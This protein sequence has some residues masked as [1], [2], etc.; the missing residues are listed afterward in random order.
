M[1][2]ASDGLSLA[3]SFI[4]TEWDPEYY[5][6]AR[7][8]LEEQPA[9]LPRS[10]P[11]LT[12]R[13]KDVMSLPWSQSYAAAAMTG[14]LPESLR[15]PSL[16]P[17]PPPTKPLA[18][19]SVSITALAPPA[20]D[21]ASAPVPDVAA[22][23][24]KRADEQEIAAILAKRADEHD[25]L[26]HWADT[27]ALKEEADGEL[28][29]P[30][31]EEEEEEEAP[32]RPVLPSAHEVERSM[33]SELGTRFT[34]YSSALLENRI[35][36]ER[37]RRATGGNLTGHLLDANVTDYGDLRSLRT[38]LRGIVDEADRRFEL[39]EQLREQQ[40][41]EA[42]AAAEE[43]EAAAAA[44]AASSPASPAASSPAGGN[45][46]CS[47]A[48]GGG[49]S[50]LDLARSFGLSASE[51]GGGGDGGGGGGDG[52]GGGDGRLELASPATSLCSPSLLRLQSPARQPRPA[53]FGGGDASASAPGSSGGRT[54]RLGA[55]ASA[56]VV[57]VSVPLP[58]EMAPVPTRLP[59]HLSGR[60]S[61][62]HDRSPGA[63]LSPLPP[64]PAHPT[65]PCR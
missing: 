44:A 57:A 4:T 5:S 63:P 19:I 62:L 45:R 30:A 41:A 48:D 55:S 32:R 21:A 64:P 8:T 18:P 20:S 49:D 9:L 15:P 10:E 29:Q 26:A 16:P 31:L 47:F 7:H 28:E 61:L 23:Q 33:V 36:N 43:E 17:V 52:S 37:L 38:H 34:R 60:R 2:K 14:V 54:Q 50:R 59:Q 22:V 65:P 11:R 39:S 40:L 35:G 25:M 51:S 27:L 12:R 24:A 42:L 58:R 53:T 56:P 3:Q 6:G 46:C 13:Q 1:A